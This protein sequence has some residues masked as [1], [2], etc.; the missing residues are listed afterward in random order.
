MCATSQQFAAKCCAPQDDSRAASLSA[1][2]ATRP[3]RPNAQGNAG[4]DLRLARFL[5][6]KVNR[7][8][9]CGPMATEWIMLIDSSSPV[10]RQKCK[11]CVQR[12]IA[13]CAAGIVMMTAVTI[14]ALLHDEH[15]VFVD[16]PSV[17]AL[18]NS[19]SAGALA[20]GPPNRMLAVISALSGS[21][22]A[23]VSGL[24]GN[25]TECRKQPT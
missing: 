10:F 23:I 18:R 16:V 6:L 20:E 21:E 5:Q 8:I 24:R 12:S 1:Q 4:I 14:A 17:T 11:L 22:E 2:S 19:G 25:C 7:Q 13:F 3:L 9:A 15:A